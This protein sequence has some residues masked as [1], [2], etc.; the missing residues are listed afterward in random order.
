MLVHVLLEGLHNQAARK[1]NENSTIG[2][3]FL[4]FFC[5]IWFG[6]WL[7]LDFLSRNWFWCHRVL[8][9][10]CLPSSYPLFFLHSPSFFPSQVFLTGTPVFC[11]WYHRRQALVGRGKHDDSGKGQL[12]Q[13]TS[14][15][16]ELTNGFIDWC[17]RC[18]AGVVRNEL[19]G[20]RQHGPVVGLVR[21]HATVRATWY[22]YW[23]VLIA[24]RG[25]GGRTHLLIALVI[26][27]LTTHPFRDGAGKDFDSR[28]RCCDEPR[29][30]FHGTHFKTGGTE[31]WIRIDRVRIREANA[32]SPFSYTHMPST[33]MPSKACETLYNLR[34][35]DLPP[36]Y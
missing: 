22:R 13:S 23:G 4:F 17:P 1:S 28:L 15:L 27:A 3:S 11:F 8:S 20:A 21:T 25:G 7:R 19:Q 9:R 5:R 30:A 26:L 16:F 33:H 10:P 6:F 32:S 2:R 29:D 24:G 35:L 12:N 31:P 14:H 18:D 36:C 34:I